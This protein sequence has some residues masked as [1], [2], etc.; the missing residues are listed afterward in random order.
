[1][2]EWAQGRPFRT[3]RAQPWN[4]LPSFTDDGASF[5][6]HRLCL[7]SCFLE[8]R[9][10]IN[11][12]YHSLPEGDVSAPGGS[13]G[14]TRDFLSGTRF[15][16]RNSRDRRRSSPLTTGSET[17]VPHKTL[18]PVQYSLDSAQKLAFPGRILFLAFAPLVFTLMGCSERVERVFVS[19][20]H[21]LKLPEGQQLQLRAGLERLFGTPDV[22]RRMMRGE[23]NAARDD[24][25]SDGSPKAADETESEPPLLQ[26]VDA[27]RLKHGAAI[28]EARCSGCHG[29]SGDG[30]GEAAAYLRPKPRDYRKGVF[31]FTSTPYG[32][33][34]SRQDL[35]RI[36]RR[37]AKGTSM[38]SFPWMTEEDLEAVIDYVLLLTYRGEVEESVAQI[39]ELDYEE[40]DEVPFEDFLVALDD[41]RERWASAESQITQAVSVAPPYGEESI[42]KGR[43]LFMSQNCYKCH[44]E[45]AEGQ[46]EWL[47]Q[48]FIDAQSK[49]PE[50]ERVAINYDAWGNPA[51]AADLTA[52]MLHGGR[53]DIDIYRRIHSGINGTPMPAFADLFRDSPENFWHLVHYVRHIVEGGDP[54]VP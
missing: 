5:S 3:H 40:G 37:G 50:A 41:T 6:Q 10:S 1:M 2:C 18:K 8:C 53:R 35:V 24:V 33:K 45:N 15:A 21:V 29:I 19:S 11:E 4:A 12:A 42:R 34:P 25:A 14:S 16:L 46:T 52:R 38:P 44:G 17:L 20:E 27:A 36:I 47:S 9:V 28:Y 31:K 43:E 54:K 23:E 30:M 51:P 26:E 49:L 13:D 7:I 32:G 22:P 39:M 48:N